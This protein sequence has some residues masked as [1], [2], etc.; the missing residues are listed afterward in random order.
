ATNLWSV[1][2]SNLDLSGTW[3]VAEY[4]P[5]AKVMIFYSAEGGT[6]YKLNAS[7]QI[8]AIANPP[9]AMYDG[10]S[11]GAPIVGHTSAGKFLALSAGT[12]VLYSYDVATDSWHTQSSSNQP[13]L[14]AKPVVATLVPSAGVIFYAACKVAG[15][16]Q[17]YLYK[18]N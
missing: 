7:G 16:C 4:D 1:L 14:S 12:R 9:F 15:H 2:A 8:T 17:A 5:V 11:Y 10:T 6:M 18:P 3:Q 13:D